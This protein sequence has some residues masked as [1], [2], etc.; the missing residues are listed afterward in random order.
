MIR[1][2]SDDNGIRSSHTLGCLSQLKS[3]SVVS[4]TI[5]DNLRHYRT[6]GRTSVRTCNLKGIC[7]T[8]PNPLVVA[9]FL[10][11]HSFGAEVTLTAVT[12]VDSFVHE[13]ASA[14]AG[15]AEP[16]LTEVIFTSA[17]KPRAVRRVGCPLLTHERYP[18][19]VKSTSCSSCR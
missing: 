6:W 4:Y 14:S 16:N 15:K 2:I 11:R 10:R 7:H 12:C 9:S 17:P 5:L 1:E 8:M 13:V 3:W 19:E 18:A